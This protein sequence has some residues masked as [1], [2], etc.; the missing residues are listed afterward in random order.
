MLSFIF[1]IAFVFLSGY[2]Y[3]QVLFIVGLYLCCRCHWRFNYQEGLW[4]LLPFI[5]R[6][7]FVSVLIQNIDFKRIMLCFEWFERRDDCTF[8]WWWW[9]WSSSLINFFFLSNS[10][11][12]SWYISNNNTTYSSGKPKNSIYIEMATATDWN[13]FSKW[14]MISHLFY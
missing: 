2:Q 11:Q 9:N 10:R 14:H 7:M 4:S 1:V 12:Y 6:I 8:C 5:S 3:V 13:Q